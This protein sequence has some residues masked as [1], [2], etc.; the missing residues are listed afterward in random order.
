MKSRRTKATSIPR[1]V[2][3]AVWER[4]EGRC[5]LCGSYEAGPYCHFIRRS[6]G[7]MGIEENIWTGCQRCHDLFDNVTDGWWHANARLNLEEHFKRHYERWD[8]RKLIYTKYGG[9][10]DNG[11]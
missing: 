1:R 7:G 5:V 2:M 10:Y 6:Q 4:D 3:D 9:I 11:C 8:E